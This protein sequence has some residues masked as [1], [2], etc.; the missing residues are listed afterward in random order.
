MT[1]STADE[2]TFETKERFAKSTDPAAVAV[3]IG[4]EPGLQLLGFT[5]PGSYDA[6]SQSFLHQLLTEILEP[7]AVITCGIAHR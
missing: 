3:V 4:G 6:V 5:G 2:D 7:S 1:L